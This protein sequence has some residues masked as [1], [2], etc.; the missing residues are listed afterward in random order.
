MTKRVFLDTNHWITLARVRIGNEEDVDKIRIYDKIKKQ[1]DSGKILFPF[2]LFHLH[3]LLKNK[4]KKQR[5]EVIDCIVDI[6]KG[7]V[8]KTYL[9]FRKQEIENA[10]LTKMGKKPLHDIRSQI[11]GNGIAYTAGDEYYF[12]SKTMAGKLWI[13]KNEDKLKKIIDGEKTMRYFLGNEEFCK[14]V[15]Q[16]RGDLKGLAL[17]LENNRD[18]RKT[19]SKSQVWDN[20]IGAIFTGTVEPI[21]VEQIVR[22]NFDR[23]K[24]QELFKTKSDIESFVGLLPSIDTHVRLTFARDNESPQRAIKPND[25]VDINLLAGAIPYCDI[26]VTEKMFANLALKQKLYKKHNCYIISDIKKIEKFLE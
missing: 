19:W 25:S 18:H 14:I 21:L 13:L 11:L 24:I 6:S 8:L 9:H 7:Y 22:H 2:S 12:N 5:N 17:K 20:E 4:N 1:A 10:L 3:D 26:V 23:K 16:S 15:N